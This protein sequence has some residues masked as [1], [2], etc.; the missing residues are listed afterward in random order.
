MAYIAAGQNG[1]HDLRGFLSRQVHPPQP[2]ADI[3]SQNIRR[4]LAEHDL[5]ATGEFELA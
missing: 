2:M 5:A 4:L 1:R 3:L